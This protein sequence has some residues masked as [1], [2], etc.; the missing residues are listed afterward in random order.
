MDSSSLLDKS[1]IEASDLLPG[2]FV[3]YPNVNIRALGTESGRK[4]R[5]HMAGWSLAFHDS[6][7]CPQRPGT[8]MMLGNYI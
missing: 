3:S 5:S 2:S 6:N 1:V 7:A 8:A 4:S